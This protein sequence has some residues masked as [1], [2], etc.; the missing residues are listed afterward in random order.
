MASKNNARASSMAA[1]LGAACEGGSCTIPRGHLGGGVR[2]SMGWRR[3]T[4]LVLA[5]NFRRWSVKCRISQSICCLPVSV[6][7]SLRSTLPSFPS[8]YLHTS[9]ASVVRAYVLRFTFVVWRMEQRMAVESGWD[10]CGSGR[11]VETAAGTGRWR[12]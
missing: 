3:A 4:G 6:T 8:K 9:I 12:R 7:R 5:A 11:W 10:R 2:V 1:V